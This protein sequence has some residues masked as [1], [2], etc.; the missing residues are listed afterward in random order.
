MTKWLL[1]WLPGGEA[2]IALDRIQDEVFALDDLREDFVYKHIPPAERMKYI[3]AGLYAGRQA[4]ERYAGQDLTA[5][6][7]Q[8]GVQIHRIDTPSPTLMHAQIT[9]DK[10]LRQVDIFTNTAHRISRAAAQAGYAM[11]AEQVERVFLAHEFYH[12]LEYSGRLCPV[13][14]TLSVQVRAL[15]GIWCRQA[16]VHR[17][18]E[19]AAFVF[20]KEYCGMTVHPKALDHLLLCET[21]GEPAENHFRVLEENY[22]QACCF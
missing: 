14:E 15:G 19:I 10:K 6:L 17:T 13:E 11:E 2:V 8:D 12:W 5:L 22:K 9:Y 3:Q 21:L 4:A 7:R 18:G 1:L 20:A 16:Q